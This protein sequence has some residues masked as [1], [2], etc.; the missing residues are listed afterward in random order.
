MLVWMSVFDRP[1]YDVPDMKPRDILS[2]ESEIVIITR[3]SSEEEVS[4][5]TIVS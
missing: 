1:V 2:V 4:L 5:L 3:S